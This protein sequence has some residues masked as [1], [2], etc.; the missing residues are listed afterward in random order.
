MDVD[1]DAAGQQHGQ[2]YGGRTRDG[3]QTDVFSEL[4]QST[5]MDDDALTGETEPE[6]EDAA[7]SEAPSEESTEAATEEESIEGSAAETSA[8]KEDNAADTETTAGGE[9]TESAAE[10]SE[11]AP[12]AETEG[13]AETHEAVSSASDI[14]KDEEINPNGDYLYELSATSTDG[15][16]VVTATMDESAGIETGTTIHAEPI[17]GARL[18]YVLRV[19]GEAAGVEKDNAYGFAYDVYFLKNGKRVE[20]NESIHISMQ[21]T[22]PMTIDIPAGSEVQS[23]QLCHIHN[24]DV[25]VLDS[26]IDAE[27]N[28]VSAAEFDLSSFSPVVMLADV[29]QGTTGSSSNLADFLSGDSAVEISGIIKNDEGKYV[30]RPGASFKVKLTA[31]EKSGLQFDNEALN[32]TLPEGFEAVTLSGTTDIEITDASGTYTVRDNTWK[33]EE[34]VLTFTWNQ[35]SE[36]YSKLTAAANVNFW[37][38]L[39]GKISEDTTSIQWSTDCKTEF[40]IDNSNYVVVNKECND[41]QWAD[42]DKSV[43]QFKVTVKSTG[44]SQNVVVTD[45]ITGTAMKL[46]QDSVTVSSDKNN[47]VDVTDKSESDTGFTYKFA[48]MQDGETITIT[49]KAKVDFCNI[50]GTTTVTQTGNTV[51]AKSD[52]M[53]KPSEKKDV[54]YKYDTTTK[55]KKEKNG[56]VS[57][58]DK[59][60]Y[61]TISWKITYNKAC[62]KSVAGH[63]VTD[64]IDAGSQSIMDYDGDVTIKVYDANWQQVGEARTLTPTEG[65]KT[66]TYEIPTTDTTA[67][68]YVF[69][70]KTRVDVSKLLVSTTVKNHVE[71]DQDPGVND[72]EGVDV[73]PGDDSKVALKKEVEKISSTEV[74]WKI[75][76]TVPAGGLNQ[77]VLTDIYPTK[78]TYKDTLKTD[79]VEVEGLQKNDQGQAI[80]AYD[81]NT[82]DNTK[83]VITFYKDS[84]KTQQ[85]LNASADKKARTIIVTLTTN[86]DTDWYAAAKSDSN[87][88]NHTNKA[89]FKYSDEEP[90]D[91]DATAKVMPVNIAKNGW[92][93]GETE[94]GLPKYHYTI[95]LGGVDSKEFTVTDTFP[96]QYLKHLAKDGDAKVYVGDKNNA[97]N[98]KKEAGTYTFAS[99]ESGGTFNVTLSGEPQSNKFYKIEYYLQVKDA[100][101]F[102]ALQ[103]AAIEHSVQNPWDNT[104]YDAKVSLTNTA[105]F[106]GVSSSEVKIDYVAKILSKQ[107]LTSDDD[108]KKNK[109]AEYKIVVNPGAAELNGGSDMELVDEYSANQNIDPN[110]IKI[111]IDPAGKECTYHLEDGKL[112][113]TIPDS[114]SVVITYSA[115]FGGNGQIQLTNKAKLKNSYESDQISKQIT[116]TSGGGGSIYSIHV[117]K[118]DEENES[119]KL[120]GAEFELYKKGEGD[121]KDAPVIDKNNK[122]VKYTTDKEGSFTVSGHQDEDGWTLDNESTYYLKETKAP[123]DYQLN[124]G[125][126]ANKYYFK[127]GDSIDT[128]NNIYLNGGFMTITNKKKPEVKITSI[129]VEKDWNDAGN[130]DGKRPDSVKVQLFA[131]VNDEEVKNITGNDGEA[132]QTEKELSESNSWV[133]TW[134]NLPKTDANGNNISYKVKESGESSGSVVFDKGIDSEVTYTVKYESSSDEDGNT[135]WTVTNSYTPAVRS[136]KVEKKWTGSTSAEELLRPTSIE[137]QLYADGEPYRINGEDAKLTLSASAVG[138]QAWAD[139]WDNLP[140]NKVKDGKSTPI[141]Y[142]I[143]EIGEQN[144][145]VTF[146]AEETKEV[147]YSV[148]YSTPPVAGDTTFVI[149]NSYNKTKVKISKQDITNS[150][151]LAGA[152]LTIT[153]GSNLDKVE[154]WTSTS[155][156]HE[157]ELADGEYT[158]TETTAPQGYQVAES[159]VFKVENQKVYIKNAENEWVP[160]DGNMVIMKDQPIATPETKKETEPET[161]TTTVPET[162][163]PETTTEAE[164]SAVPETETTTVPETTRSN[165]GNGGGSGGGGGG[166]WHAVTTAAATEPNT[167]ETTTAEGG[168]VNG[169]SRDGEVETNPDGSVRGAGR[170]RNR[171]GDDGDVNGARRGALTGDQAMTLLWGAG[172]MCCAIL[173]F[174]WVRRRKR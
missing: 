31:K 69:E 119:I 64:T 60:G 122:T 118:T 160:Q 108:L 144:G 109:K 111:V 124:T 43:V 61:R 15:K 164:T 130:R 27:D 146:H 125:D 48:S 161:E 97:G 24:K 151:E 34:G 114:T 90:I 106:N 88:Y 78:N 112:T 116:V 42:N 41:S 22:E 19:A 174:A 68:R 139:G 145:K 147:T 59:D 140:V 136:I 47:S 93:D 95:V 72:D 7:E 57:D 155:E 58:V 32:Y 153:S 65:A 165:G 29:M 129:G 141:T 75:T 167:E 36:Y 14:T 169:D 63:K 134:S 79:T 53:D 100:N 131:S 126:D 99:T 91:D 83:C 74:S 163:A 157:L 107:L 166:E 84:G 26:A 52:G 121:Q 81:V 9:E 67:Y 10:Q 28:A 103:K 80:E 40:A 16:V 117:S 152:K 115:I 170:G 73:K 33:I 156:P 154:E 135:R 162:T 6:S 172:F 86:V 49:Y 44:E 101:A 104:G 137:V 85:G 168:D 66:W 11:S 70:Y 142:T 3:G 92:A 82:D 102:K 30:V 39:T 149:T 113:F 51:T 94:D 5:E 89:E 127:I 110:S 132:V 37:I 71:D 98:I 17:T 1:C 77:A 123:A 150:K 21:Y 96:T 120:A 128:A 2:C 76:M 138:A 50:S 143:K 25:E 62:A 148:S 12:E 105:T 55:L 13:T 46:I 23:L 8:E 38:D 18:T 159:I 56:N 133:A 87:L 20:P 35:E 45:T 173:L 4:A 158:L 171:N 54:Y